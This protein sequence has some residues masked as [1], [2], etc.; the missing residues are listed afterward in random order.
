MGQGGTRCRGGQQARSTKLAAVCTTPRTRWLIFC[1]RSLRLCPAVLLVLRGE[2]HLCVDSHHL[3][4][5]HQPLLLPPHRLF[6][7]GKHARPCLMP[8]PLSTRANITLHWSVRIALCILPGVSVLPACCLVAGLGALA[9]C[10]GAVPAVSRALP[11][12]PRLQFVFYLLWINCLIAFSFLL[13]ALFRSSKTGEL[14][15][16]S[17]FWTECRAPSWAPCHKL[18]RWLV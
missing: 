2:L 10:E 8:L 13:S 17:Q 1:R 15:C 7:P 3:R 4:Q 12:P 9:R 18:L 16:C 11:T 5:R 14:A 6:V